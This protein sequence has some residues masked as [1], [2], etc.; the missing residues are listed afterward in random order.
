M[1]LGRRAVLWGTGSLGL[2]GCRAGPDSADG[3]TAADGTTADSDTATTGEPLASCADQE[4]PAELGGE[5]YEHACAPVDGGPIDELIAW[6]ATATRDELFSGVGQR[7]A[8]GLSIDEFATA[9]YIAQ[10][11]LWNDGDEHR[12]LVIPSARA[13]ADMPA[14]HPPMLALMWCLGR[15]HRTSLGSSICPAP[16]VEP[17]PDPAA[18][19]RVRAALEVG[20]IEAADAAVV[21]ALRGR[22]LAA[23]RDLLLEYGAS[24]HDWIGHTMIQ[25]AQAM[26]VLAASGGRGAEPILRSLVRSIRAA[27]D[28]ALTASYYANRERI[29]SI[30][31]AT[32]ASTFDEG[33]ALELLAHLRHADAESAADAT[34]TM[35]MEG[36]DPSTIWEA[37]RL[38]AAELTLRFSWPAWIKFPIHAVTSNNAMRVA[39]DMTCD[40][41]LRRLLLLQATSWVPIHRDHAE[42][43]NPSEP[44]S[45]WAIDVLEPEGDPSAS[46]EEILELAGVNRREGVRHALAWLR[47]GG[48]PLQL[49]A[50][51]L[52]I[53]VRNTF[54]EHE[55]KH[56]VAA[57]EEAA[58][59][60]PVFASVLWAAGLS[61]GAEPSGAAWNGHDEAVAALAGLG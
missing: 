61:F 27:P 30:P 21:A 32:G 18:L 43:Y 13:L 31:E 59:A 11:T 35:L 22:Q 49:R 14:E 6:L 26:R 5:V 37:T 58:A 51:A 20:D 23:L 29:A 39:H 44:A 36:V 60:Q 33:A 1:R 10:I 42:S 8:N 40:T 34:S 47:E 46:L 17:D 16:T 15:N 57:F 24:N 50:R 54:E 45:G 28:L 56:P 48:D 19:D 55:L 41:R 9:I 2:A 7:L 4:E 38:A 3:P 12:R 53:D 25:A 52:E